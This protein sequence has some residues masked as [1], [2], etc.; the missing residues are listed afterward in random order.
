[1]NLMDRIVVVAIIVVMAIG[2]FAGYT[3][4]NSNDVKTDVVVIGQGELL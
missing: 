1:M 2:L 3:A 4:N